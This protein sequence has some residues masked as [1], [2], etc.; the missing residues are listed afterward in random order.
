[1]TLE[2]QRE[3]LKQLKHNG[4]EASSA[5]KVIT[6]LYRRGDIVQAN[7][8]KPPSKKGGASTST[9]GAIR[10]TLSAYIWGSGKGD[11]PGLD[12]SIVAV[13]ALKA[14]AGRATSLTGPTTTAEIHTVKTFAAAITADNTRDAEAVIA[15]M[16]GQG[17]ASALYTDVDEDNAEPV[18]GVKLGKARPIDADKGVLRTKAAL[19]RM[20]DM[21]AHLDAS[22][23]A[24]QSAAVAAAKSG[25]KGAALARLRKKKVLDAKLASARSAASKLGDVLMAVDE[26]E[27]NREA[28]S[29]LETGMSSLKSAT[30]DGVTADRIDAVASEF[31]DAMAEQQDV[32]LAFEQLNMDT[33]GTDAVL[34]EEL[35]ELMEAGTKTDEPK[36]EVRKES[37]ETSKVA[38]EAEAELAK[39]LAE[40]PMPS[41]Y[42][43][44]DA[45][46]EASGKPDNAEETGGEK[47][48]EGSSAVPT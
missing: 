5:M 20:E 9:F 37:T 26:A 14:A 15:H 6:E 39:L 30:K 18:L 2:I 33:S 23:T 32:R 11:E 31:D 8:L 36:A 1:M 4:R 40:L 48:Q 38:D 24:E 21:A 28:V 42:K 34:E 16:V 10:S 43:G 29:A 45:R 41:P 12:D 46:T 27:S 35:N 19:E 7:K 22:V 25:D 17:V 47:N 13:A 44:N 3:L